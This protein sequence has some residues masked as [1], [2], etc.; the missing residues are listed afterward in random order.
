MRNKKR[1]ILS[2]IGLAPTLEEEE[3]IE[4][5]NNTYKSAKVGRYGGISISAEEVI[6]NP[7][8][9]G[10]DAIFKSIIAR[11]KKRD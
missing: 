7:E 1:K 6:N 5:I 3:M 2:Y 11:D 9:K 4:I 10:L 8:F